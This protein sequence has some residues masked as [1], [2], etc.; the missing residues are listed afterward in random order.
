MPPP[1]I[2]VVAMLPAAAVLYL[3][4]RTTA[5]IVRALVKKQPVQAVHCFLIGVVLTVTYLAA[6]L[7]FSV[8]AWL[9]HSEAAKQMVPC[10]W[11]CL[12]V[13]IVALPSAGLFALYKWAKKAGARAQRSL[14]R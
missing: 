14:T 9:S 1:T 3:L 8:S 10:Y 2:I 7:A 6:S 11:L 12:F 5:G 13:V 4:V